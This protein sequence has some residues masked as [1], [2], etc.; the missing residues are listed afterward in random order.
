MAPYRAH[1]TLLMLVDSCFSTHTQRDNVASLPSGRS[2][3]LQGPTSLLPEFFLLQGPPF[4]SYLPISS[5][6]WLLRGGPRGLLRAEPDASV[7]LHF[8]DGSRG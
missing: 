1:T 2:P 4:P 3:E 7:C 6:Y 8:R 5:T